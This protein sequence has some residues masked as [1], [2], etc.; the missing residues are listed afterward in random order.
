MKAVPPFK[1]T[2]I[3]V[4]LVSVTVLS[5]SS[6]KKINPIEMS[7]KNEVFAKNEAEET[8]V[9]FFISTANVSKGIISKSQIAKQKSSDVSI[10]QLSTRIEMQQNQLLDELSK[11]ANNKLIVINE[12][13]AT[14]KRDLYD[15]IDATGTE[16]NDEYMIS[17]TEALCD[18]IDLFESISKETNDKTILQLVLKF[19]PEQYRL[20]REAESLQKQNT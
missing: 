20:L 5:A 14:H 3:K 15:L 18:Q 11:I 8:E 4:F 13:N 7:L 10:Q 12:I 2:F 16:F 9:F 1:A 19:L 6:C 17:I